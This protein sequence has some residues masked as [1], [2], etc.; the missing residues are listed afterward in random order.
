MRRQ[1]ALGWRQLRLIIFG[2]ILDSSV[3]MVIL[4]IVVQVAARRLPLPGFQFERE[5]LPKREARLLAPRVSLPSRRMKGPSS[6]QPDFANGL[7]EHGF[8]P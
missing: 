2:I 1:R 7:L 8:Q 4:M 5:C 3:I 6:D